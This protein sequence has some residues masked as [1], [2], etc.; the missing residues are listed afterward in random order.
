MNWYDY[1]GWVATI[2]VLACYAW[3]IKWF[4]IANVVLCVPVAL[5]GIFRGSYNGAFISLTFGVIGAVNLVKERRKAWET[6]EWLEFNKTG[7]PT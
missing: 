5:P 4:N 7:W 6:D 2:L 1:L 3:R